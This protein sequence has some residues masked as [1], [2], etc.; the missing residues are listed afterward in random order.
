MD[1]GA[2]FYRCDFQVHTPRDLSWKGKSY[3]KEDDRKEYAIS[4]IAACREKGINGIAITDHHDLCFVSYVREAAENEKSVNGDDIPDNEKLIVFPGIELTLNVP[5]QAILLLD[6]D[7]TVTILPQILTVLAITHSPDNAAKAAPV[8]RLNS[9]STLEQLKEK[10]DEHLFLKDRY[11]ILPNVTSGGS[12][13]L[14]REGV[15]NK[16]KTMPC[17]GGYLDGS[18]DKCKIGDLRILDGKD[19]HYGIK[20]VALFQTSDSRSE[21]H[22]QLG[23]CSTWVKWAVPTAEAIRQACLAQE[24]RISQKEPNLPSVIIR[25]LHVSNSEFMGPVDLDFN[26]QYNAI[27]GSRGTGKSTILEYL[28]W[29]L[30]DEHQTELSQDESSLQVGQRK[31]IEN[32]L[33]KYDASV[34]VR[35]E[36]NGVPHLVR[37]KAKTGEVLLKIDDAQ[38]E[39]CSEEDIKTLLPIQAYSQKQLSRVGVRVD[40]LNRFVQSGIKT[41]LDSIAIQLRS[42]VSQIRQSYSHVRRK[43]VVTN[44]LREDRLNL[45][46][47]S[48]QAKAIRESLSGLTP[49]Q[50]IL[51]SKQPLY[52]SADLLANKWESETLEVNATISEFGQLLENFPSKIVTELSEHPELA[53]LNEMQNTLASKSVSLRGL[54]AKM[55][56]E[57]SKIVSP[58]GNF[59]GDYQEARGKWASAK[60][61]FESKYAAA[62]GAASSHESQLQALTELEEKITAI[63]KRISQADNE[64]GNLGNPEEGFNNLRKQWVECHKV[65]GNLYAT[66]CEMLTGLSG[67][68]IKANALRGA[69]I[70]ELEEA[71]RSI[72]KGTGLRSQKIEDLL[73]KITDDK[74]PIILWDSLLNEFEHLA[75][76]D[77]SNA[78]GLALP[79]SPGLVSCGLTDGDLNKLSEKLTPEAWLELLLTSLGDNTSFEYKTKEGEYI[80]FEHASAGQQATA[81]LFT[82]LN[83]PGPPLIID[84]PED[85]LDN[86]IIF[87][88]VKRIWDA[89]TRRQIIFTSH[90]ANLVVNGDAELV[91][92]CDYR[93]AGD[94][95]RGRI[96]HE[97]AIDMPEIR[98]TIKTIMEGGEKAFKLRLDKYGF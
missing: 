71:I 32:T 30:C 12:D 6:A 85:D 74:D 58:E 40:E 27:I 88:I 11:I 14:L 82:L 80:P 81:L 22:S 49:T 1:K 29:A 66:Q 37:R 50:Q 36:V 10:L 19:A 48:K 78:E 15:A 13:T 83:Q 31:L 87:D 26:P 54:V 38:L 61:N 73:G 16:Y 84:Q 72:T 69:N 79:E 21:D 53:V 97:G 59:L 63:S 60:I 86:Q 2:H 65:R 18:I 93:I 35:F 75:L 28:R 98:D 47:L 57:F 89:K 4:L 94:Y 52:L 43:Q 76:H 39:D 33:S 56:E 51:L 92:C 20:R 7:F 70:R 95:S 90:N 67:G 17:V 68:A 44:S 23:I 91:V 45:E 64:I 42:I 3:T 77:P 96:S 5:C 34:E 41:N 25:S 24:S 8:E 46:S 62:K 9:I 55:K